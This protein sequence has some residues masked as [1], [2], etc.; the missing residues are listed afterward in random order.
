MDV[1]NMQD[2]ALYVCD[3]SKALSKK[4]IKMQITISK[5]K[6]LHEVGN[7]IHIEQETP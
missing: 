3:R 5:S 1:E 2:I 7:P 6:I 4:S